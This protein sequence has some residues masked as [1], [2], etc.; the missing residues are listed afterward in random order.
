VTRV[1]VRV[2]DLLEPL[3][4]ASDLRDY[5][6]VRFY[7]R[8]GRRLLGYVQIGNRGG[9]VGLARLTDELGQKLGAQ[10]L[11]GLRPIP[12]ALNFAPPKRRQL[13]ASD[14]VSIVVATFDRPDDLRTCLRHLKA[15]STDR[16]FQIV[17]V[18]NNPDSGL[19]NP[20][21]EENPDVVAVQ[22]RRRGLSYARN[23]G[24]LA[25]G[26]AII[27]MTDDDVVMPQDWLEK[28]LE[29]FD[30]PEVAAVTGNVLPWQLETPAQRFFE[31]YGGLGRGFEPLEVDGEWFAGA[32]FGPPTWKLGATAN[33]AFRSWIF[34]DESIGLLERALGAGMP[35]GVGED[36]YLFYRILKADQVMVYEPDA[37]LWHRHRREM[38]EIKAQLSAYS[39]GHVAYHLTTLLRDGDKRAVGYLALR[40]PWSFIWRLGS[41]IRRPGSYPLG[42]F[43]LELRGS[44]AGPLA[45][46]QSRRRV[47]REETQGFA[48][49]QK[50]VG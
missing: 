40:L 35:A 17:V 28:L 29:P 31:S 22:E 20:V 49:E 26:G 7:V 50:M 8:I 15:Q 45:Y 10:I 14:S 44:L 13:A 23:A 2:L 27:V 6:A 47:L 32:V 9:P 39:R 1:A 21:M 41:M 34:A 12:F 37:Y 5:D 18:D 4:E 36:T 33:A 30:R 43:F 25:S 3:Q 24:I 48:P 38:D 46:W 16:E 11:E 19:T 42:L